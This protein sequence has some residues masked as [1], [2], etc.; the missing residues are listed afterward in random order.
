MASVTDSLR[1]AAPHAL[2][3]RCVGSGCKVS[4]SRIPASRVVVNLESPA[5]PINRAGLHCDY[6]VGYEEGTERDGV[7]VTL[8][9]K[10]TIQAGETVRQLRAGAA[11]AEQ[12]LHDVPILR[13][14][15]VAAGSAHRQE[16]TQLRRHLVRFRGMDAPVHLIRCGDSL[17]KALR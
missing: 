10:R 1:K 6:L 14:V 17:A 2:T 11:I 3:T 5:A 4:L 9:L 12:W 8:E 13:F 7:L 16:L 15:P